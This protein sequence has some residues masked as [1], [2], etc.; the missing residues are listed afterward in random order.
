MDIDVFLVLL[1]KIIRCPLVRHFHELH[2]Q[3][4]LYAIIFPTPQATVLLPFLNPR[5][6][7]RIEKIDIKDQL[8]T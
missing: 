4:A 6:I 7:T 2:M 8:A 3:H 5:I 1:V